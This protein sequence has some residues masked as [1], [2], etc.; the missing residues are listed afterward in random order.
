MDPIMMQLGPL[1]IRWYGFLIALGVFAGMWWGMKVAE[2]R[3][4]DVEKLMDMVV[5]VMLAAIVGARLIYVVTSPSAFFGPNGNP[6]AAFYIWQGGLSI[7]GGII[8][9][10]LATW[11]YARIH[12]LNMWAYLDVMTPAGAL[13]IIGGRLG[14]FMNGSDTPGR[15][16]GW[17]VGFTWPEPGTDT[18][19]TVGRFI[20]G[21]NLWAYYP[22][23]CSLGSSVSVYDCAAFGGELLRGPVHLTQIYGA[24]IGLMLVPLLLW[25]FRR[26][27]TPGF[28]FWQF[29]LWY[30]VLRSVLEEPFRDNPLPWNVYLSEGLIQ[31]GIGIFTMTQL[32]SIPIILVSVY[33]LLTLKPA[34]TPHAASSKSATRA[35]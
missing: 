4:M 5:W 24:I 7:H 31:P 28:V 29:M 13:G 21:D 34:R 27:H 8:G 1:T 17:P 2:K 33:M 32:A 6:L 20:F 25:A 14:N 22:G 11:I 10:I 16:T 12:N 15:L 19:G 35:S 30:S 9:I 18:F 3:G 26:S 23:T